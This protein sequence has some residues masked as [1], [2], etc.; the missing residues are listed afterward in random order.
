MRWH[1]MRATTREWLH[2]DIPFDKPRPTWSLSGAGQVQA[3][4][5]PELDMLQTDGLPIF[6]KWATLVFG[7]E[8]D[9][10]RWGGIITDVVENG[11]SLTVTAEEFTA[12]PH[13]VQYTNVF[14]EIEIDPADIMRELWSH[15][16][17][18]PDGDLN[19]Q[20][21]DTTTPVRLGTRLSY[22]YDAHTDY[23]ENPDDYRYTTWTSLNDKLRDNPPVSN[24]PL[25]D[26]QSEV[27]KHHESGG[28]IY[29]DW[30][31]DGMSANA[32]YVND[33]VSDL[34]YRRGNV[35]P[36]ADFQ[37]ETFISQLKGGQLFKRF[38]GEFY[39]LLWWEH[40]D[41]GDEI[42][43]LAKETPFDYHMTHEW[44]NENK[45]DVV[46]T[47]N[48]G[49]PRLGRRQFNLRFVE[50]ENVTETLV[51]GNP[52]DYANEVVILGAGEGRRRIRTRKPSREPGRLRRPTV[53]ED[54]SVKSESRA[55][56]LADFELNM[57]NKTEEVAEVTVLDHPH[58]PLGS[59]GVGD[60]IL[61]QARIGWSDTAVWSRITDYTHRGPENTIQLKLARSDSFDYGKG[62]D[63][64]NTG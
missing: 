23:E 61:V 36:F 9:V 12:Y 24:T 27:K 39:Q 2:R 34:F 5:H 8:D 14:S 30:S 20:V 57:R 49:Y 4:V 25:E 33:F 26:Y 13:G 53:L 60:D 15:I 56:E 3:D 50:G 40:T 54:K 59:F 48:I 47:L 43:Q 17:A 62:V 11:Q 35:F 58:A 55:R 10:I 31:F 63:D 42:N 52:D 37:P 28:T 6:A 7:E 38:D 45:D 1:A 64:G 46:S 29:E 44:S 51:V 22:A 32:A 19:V 16:Q 21:D 41:I 18:F